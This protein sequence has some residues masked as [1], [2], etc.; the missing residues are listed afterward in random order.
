MELYTKVRAVRQPSATPGLRNRPGAQGMD[1]ARVELI[2]AR[3]MEMLQFLGY[4]VELF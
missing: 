1:E 2:T 4:Y 3:A